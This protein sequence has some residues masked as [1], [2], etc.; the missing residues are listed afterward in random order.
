MI[1]LTA[2]PARMQ[3]IALYDVL[4]I[5]CRECCQTGR[6]PP[7]AFL[8]SFKRFLIYGHRCMPPRIWYL[9]RHPYLYLAQAQPCSRFCRFNGS[10]CSLR[11]PFPMLSPSMQSAKVSSPWPEICPSFDTLWSC[12][13]QR[14]F[15]TYKPKGGMPTGTL[16]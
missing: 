6:N 1:W 11:P 8:R 7:G 10:L 5:G 2:T 4:C 15:P 13:I 9:H 16:V 12:I 14:T 3:R